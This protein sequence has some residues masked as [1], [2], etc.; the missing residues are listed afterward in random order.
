M[1]H[2]TLDL[3]PIFN[4]DV[5]SSSD[6]TFGSSAMFLTVGKGFLRLRRYKGEQLY[7]DSKLKTVSDLRESVF[8]VSWT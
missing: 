4:S 7:G 6:G 1:V 8:S 5:G 3:S 2:V